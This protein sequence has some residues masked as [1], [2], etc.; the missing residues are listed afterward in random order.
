VTT[1][2]VSELHAQFASA[3]PTR[4]E[5]LSHHARRRSFS[6]ER[7]LPYRKWIQQRAQS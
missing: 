7:I 1:E 4:L 5:W 6:I 3:S 2:E